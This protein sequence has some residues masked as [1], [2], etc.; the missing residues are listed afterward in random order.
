MDIADQVKDPNSVREVINNGVPASRLSHL[1]VVP[2]LTREAN[3]S[4]QTNSRSLY[5]KQYSTKEM[6]D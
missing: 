1:R 5:E 3:E 4:H 2:T 6:K